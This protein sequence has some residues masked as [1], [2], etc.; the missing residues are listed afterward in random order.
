M[1]E[2][3]RVA[4][5][6]GQMIQ[7]TEVFRDFQKYSAELE[8][9]ESSRGLLERYSAAAEEIHDREQRGDIVE[10]WEKEKLRELSEEVTADEFLMA[11][12]KVR[13]EYLGLLMTIQRAIGEGDAS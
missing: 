3:L 11:Y 12:V 1:E 9:N 8:E 4:N 5:E 7:E 10:V 6:L 13:E 2:I